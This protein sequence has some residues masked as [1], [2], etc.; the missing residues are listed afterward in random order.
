MGAC[1]PGRKR[2]LAI[3]PPKNERS[4]WRWKSAYRGAI[5][6]TIVATGSANAADMANAELQ[7]VTVTA[8]RQS[9]LLA[10]VP[11]SIH[12]IGG[13]ELGRRNI[14][15]L[16]SLA[17]STPGLYFEAGWGGEGSAPTLRGQ[18]QP[19]QAGD[20]VGIF[21]DG[22]YQSNSFGVDASML[23]LERV[24]VVEGPQSAL[25]G[26]STFAGAINY[27][28]RRPEAQPQLMLTAEAGDHDYRGFSAVASGALDETGVLARLAASA[29][30]SAGTGLNLA[31]PQQPLGGYRKSAVA[32]TFADAASAGE[33]LRL[34]ARYSRADL[35]QPAVLSISG[36]GYN[37]GSRNPDTGYWSYYC[38]ELPVAKAVDISPG[39]PAS[40]TET[41]QIAL[42]AQRTIG[43]WQLSSLS[44]YYRSASDAWRDFDA[45]S[46]GGLYGLCDI[47]LDCPPDGMTRLPLIGYAYVNQLSLDRNISRE[48]SQEVRLRWVGNTANAMLGVVASARRDESTSA[49]A[50]G[51]LQLAPGERLTALLP[52]TPTLAGPASILNKFVTSDPIAT[53][54]LRSAEV[55]YHD[56]AA[57]FGALDIH[58]TTKLRLHAELRIARE[59]D[60]DECTLVACGSASTTAS[61]NSV[62]PRISFDLRLP[63]Q[64]LLWL[65]AA[66]G[67]RSGGSNDDP[68]LIPA[69][70]E[71]RPES[72]W[73]Y[74]L[75]Y[76]GALIE[77]LTSLDA[78][79]YY[80]DWRDTQILGPSVS[81]GNDS[82]V[83]RNISGIRTDGIEVANHWR[84]TRRLQLDL[85]LALTNPRFNAGSEDVG[86]IAF[87][88]ITPDNATSTFCTA[89]LSRHQSAGGGLIVPYIDGNAV[90]RA[91]MWQWSTALSYQLPDNSNQWL[92]HVRLELGHQSSVYD[93][94]IDGAKFGERTLLASHIG[95]ARGSWSLDAWARNL[96]NARYVRMVS[97]RGPAFFPTTPRPLDLI[98][99]DGRQLG[100]SLQWQR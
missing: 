13:Q 95:F 7:E 18:A 75:G 53:Q 59:L 12:V 33:S 66:R 51:P 98:M 65:S 4:F 38:G 1:R 83:L 84:L 23:D 89:G 100:L 61:F 17:A 47:N 87:C 97:S 19:S 6:V 11:L 49:F 56:T 78:S 80:I 42:N 55:Q 63:N 54:F 73:T 34:Q 85:D 68:T 36:A 96:T 15:D 21:V 43:R 76:R 2:V 30:E 16:Q 91:P 25:Y 69:E 3:N 10:D 58:L 90:N 50:A 79:V 77:G 32:L 8:R 28:T 37:C 93:R 81:P 31:Q 35:A 46:I 71:F 20:N 22:V 29:R 88:G 64:G 27:V 39:V 86:G 60:R 45:S 99:G 74:E 14:D 41:I 48:L 5:T 82:F 62:T 24:E 57:L 70:Q 72:N 9:E 67:V 52:A 94:P 92:H 40:T 44:S 26:H